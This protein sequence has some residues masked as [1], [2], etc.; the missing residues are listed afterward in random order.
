MQYERGDGE[1]K[2]FPIL[3]ELPRKNIDTGMG[4]ER[5]AFLLQ[6]VDN[7]YEID[8]VAPVLRRA[9]ELAGVTY[10]ADHDADV[11][12]RVVADHVRPA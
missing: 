10:G 4:L 7:M 12:L 3:G 2:E 11:R 8:E 1:G 6:G 9:A 5:V